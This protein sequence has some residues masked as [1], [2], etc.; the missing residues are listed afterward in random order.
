MKRCCT[1]VIAAALLLAGLG[2]APASATE[3]QDPLTPSQW[4]LTTL[5][6]HDMWPVTTGSGVTVAVIDT[7]ADTTTEDLAGRFTTGT[8]F[9]T[10]PFTSD[11]P[12]VATHATFVSGI[13]AANRGNG[14]GIAG[15]APDTTIMPIQVFGGPDDGLPS[16]IANA[17][18][19][20]VD[21]GADI[22]NISSGGSVADPQQQVALA[23]AAAHGVLVVAAAGNTATSGNWASYP[24]SFDSVLAVTAT[25]ETNTRVP[26]ATTGPYV[27]VAAPGANIVSTSGPGTYARHTGTSFATPYVSGVA[28]LLKAAVPS[29]RPDQLSA[30][31]TTTATDLGPPGT[32]PVTGH[33]LINP[34]AALAYLQTL[35]VQ[36][37]APPAVGTAIRTTASTASSFKLRSGATL[38]VPVRVTNSATGAPVVGASVIVTATRAWR[39]GTT[40]YSGVTGTD[41][42]AKVKLQASRGGHLTVHTP[43]VPGVRF[44]SHS[45]G[46]IM[47]RVTPAVTVKL[48]RHRAVTTVRPDDGQRRILERRV[49]KR[50]TRVITGTGK[51]VSS[52]RLM[53]GV[54][55]RVRVPRQSPATGAFSRSF[56]G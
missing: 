40:D 4:A 19:W 20:A 33:G 42:V 21:H 18:V 27:D 48:R 16:D 28:A 7:P 14:I 49:G 30:A 3:V 47:L 11:D 54:R 51:V 39:P 10:Q 50:W 53:A 22:V 8:S 45:R 9:A 43:L 6:A 25:D 15:I 55:Y 38:P 12:I 37:P 23:Y 24:A 52:V 41:G 56:R 36:P 2:T 5:H 1:T 44:G 35:P 46:D 32:D 31:L 34:P 17:I 13:I 29:A 26:I